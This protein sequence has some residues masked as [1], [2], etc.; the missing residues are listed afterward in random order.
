[1]DFLYATIGNHVFQAAAVYLTSATAGFAVNIYKEKLKY[2]EEKEK[3]NVKKFE[4]TV[5][6][7][8]GI[9]K[10][11]VNEMMEISPILNNN[12]NIIKLINIMFSLINGYS[13]TKVEFNKKMKIYNNS[14]KKALEYLY[15]NRKIHTN[16]QAI[17]VLNKMTF[18][19]CLWRN[20][21]EN[22][23][24]EKT[25]YFINKT[26][27]ENAKEIENYN[28][29]MSILILKGT[30]GCCV[31]DCKNKITFLY[32]VNSQIVALE[33][34]DEIANNNNVAKENINKEIIFNKDEYYKLPNHF[35]WQMI[36]QNLLYNKPGRYIPY[37]EYSEKK[38]K[39]L[40][41]NWFDDLIDKIRRKEENIDSPIS[42]N[43][44]E[45]NF[46]TELNK[47]KNAEDLDDIYQRETFDY[48]NY[49]VN[50]FFNIKNGEDD[51]IRR[52]GFKE[53]L[54]DDILNYKK[55][56]K[57][58]DLDL[59]FSVIGNHKYNKTDLFCPYHLKYI[60]ESDEV[61]EK[62]SDLEFTVFENENSLTIN[63]NQSRIDDSEIGESLMIKYLM[64][65][66]STKDSFFNEP[67]II[68]LYHYE[69]ENQSMEFAK[70]ALLGFIFFCCT[71]MPERFSE[72]MGNIFI[73]PL[74]RK[75]IMCKKFYNGGKKVNNNDD[76]HQLKY[77]PYFLF[78]GY[79]ADLYSFSEFY[80]SK[81][82][83]EEKYQI[84]IDEFDKTFGVS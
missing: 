37:Y 25:F 33:H 79:P 41:E 64:F 52:L 21:E 67:A 9:N 44:N 11:Y 1:M 2:D 22:K 38:Y 51:D 57:D 47:Y 6:E 65:V 69:N 66:I 59:K 13:Q 42:N 3:E 18:L 81:K 19:N 50:L 58:Q 5:N 40:D 45:P 71:I 53:G 83:N 24:I 16:R 20:I 48:S 26:L 73:D 32:M 34:E 4:K 15:M 8:K 68:Y 49:G 54:Q 36:K 7:I 35:L 29:M 61:L 30:H 14:G 60:I 63:L 10:K 17:D 75:F 82:I 43:N 28:K 76:I 55:K 39:A 46:V 78:S 56:V 62:G 74:S 31:K 70:K 27:V 84:L 23:K 80:E 72:I 12:R 77:Q